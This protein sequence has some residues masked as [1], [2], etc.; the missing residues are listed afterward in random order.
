[1]TDPARSSPIDASPLGIPA[2][3]PLVRLRARSK[4]AVGS[5]AFTAIKSHAL[6]KR[7]L[8]GGANLGLLTGS[9]SGIAVVDIDHPERFAEMVAAFG[10]LTLFVNSGRGGGRG[11][12]YVEWAPG[13]PKVFKWNDTKVGEILGDGQYVVVPP[14]IHPDTGRRYTW[15]VDPLRTPVPPLPLAWQAHLAHHH[16]DRPRHQPAEVPAPPP[17]ELARRQMLALAQPGARRTTNGRIKF[18]CPACL[19]SHEDNA[20]LFPSGL[21]GCS[22]DD[23]SE[24]HKAALRTL[25][26]ITAGPVQSDAWTQQQLGQIIDD[27]SQHPL[28]GRFG[29]TDTTVVLAH[30]TLALRLGRWEYGAAERQVAELAGL[31]RATVHRCHQRL[32]RVGWLVRRRRGSRAGSPAQWT[33]VPRRYRLRATGAKVSIRDQSYPSRG[34]QKKEKTGPLWK[35]SVDLAAIL[36]HDCFRARIG[37][38]PGCRLVY[39]RLLD[40]GPAG[41]TLNVFGPARKATVWRQLDRLRTF[42][43]ARRDRRT[44]RWVLGSAA[45]DRVVKR[46]KAD[47]RLARQQA[48]HALD[49]DL[50]FNDPTVVRFE[51]PAAARYPTT[52]RRS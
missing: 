20:I 31:K 47:G 36:A 10:A 26:G 41:I 3:W 1:M 25:F 40:A 32:V 46:L 43:L 18:Q 39:I 22:Q 12:A 14:S 44:R 16:G 34:N 48:Q 45:L 42:N 2:A 50:W 38:G 6:A 28:T 9:Q 49:R 27:L 30:A 11:H 5:G 21:V 23:A 7:Y 4:K 52:L 33:L 35:P 29:I 13:L 19:D 17:D 8:D 24:T 37:L 51:P 15:A